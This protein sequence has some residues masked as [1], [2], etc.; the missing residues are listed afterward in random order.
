M[1]DDPHAVRLLLHGGDEALRAD[2]AQV[3]ELLLLRG[4]RRQ[5]AEPLEHHLLQVALALLLQ[6]RLAPEARLLHGAVQ[7]VD[8]A[9][10]LGALERLRLRAVAD[11]ALD[12]RA[13]GAHADGLLR[14]R[15]ARGAERLLDR[16]AALG[17]GVV[18]GVF[19][20]RPVVVRRGG[21]CGRGGAGRPVEERAREDQLVEICVLRW[22]FR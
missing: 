6:E 10:A 9:R 16:R 5:R 13:A 18:V 20:V 8:V 22:V 7:R 15:V 14:R 17:V 2:L 11:D 4:R 12:A 1:D 21:A 3:P 19:G